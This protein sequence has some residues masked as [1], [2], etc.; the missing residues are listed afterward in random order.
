MVAITISCPKTNADL[1]GWVS[2]G[3]NLFH[4]G[5][6]E[7]NGRNVFLPVLSGQNWKKLDKTGKNSERCQKCLLSYLTSYKRLWLQMHLVNWY[8]LKNMMQKKTITLG[9][10]LPVL[11]RLKWKKLGHNWG[12]FER[13]QKCSKKL[14]VIL[15]FSQKVMVT[16]ALSWLLLFGNMI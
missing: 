6:P 9:L 4:P 15:I 8:S 3:R 13:C 14:I 16:Y 1:Q 10:F 7:K 12:N 11:S 2:S 5:H